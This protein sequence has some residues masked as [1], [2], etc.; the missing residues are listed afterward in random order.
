MDCCSGGRNNNNFPLLIYTRSA[1]CA[2]IIV[3]IRHYLRGLI[4]FSAAHPRWIDK[5][6]DYHLHAMLL[7][8]PTHNTHA[9]HSNSNSVSQL[10]APRRLCYY[11]YK[12]CSVV[13][14]MLCHATYE[15]DRM[16][17]RNLLQGEEEGEGCRGRRATLKTI[18]DISYILVGKY[19]EAQVEIDFNCPHWIPSLHMGCGFKL[20]SIR[21]LFAHHFSL[22]IIFCPPLLRFDEILIAAESLW[23]FVFMA[24]W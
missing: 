15:E 16:D 13:G 6:C 7:H 4:P 24:V 5:S 21:H 18:K 11:Y 19:I 1:E 3:F 12:G 20:P 2:H 8:I 22:A 10:Y 9:D 14:V 17:K 23:T